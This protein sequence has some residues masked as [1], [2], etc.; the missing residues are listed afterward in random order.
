MTLRTLM[1]L[2]STIFHGGQ[3][4]GFCMYDYIRISELDEFMTLLDQRLSRTQQ[5]QPVGL[6]AKKVRRVGEAFSKPPP[7]GA[8]VDK[9][10][11]E[12][13][14]GVLCLNIRIYCHIMIIIFF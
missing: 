5:Q 10:Y 14:V 1:V 6:V 7:P 12:D 3:K 8:A 13:I 4:V 9:D 2:Y 11:R